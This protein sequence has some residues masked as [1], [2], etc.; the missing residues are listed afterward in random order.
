MS[1]T[2]P[3]NPPL[4]LVYY[5]KRNISCLRGGREFEKGLSPLS[6]GYSPEKNG[7]KLL[8]IERD[9]Q[10]ITVKR[11]PLLKVKRVV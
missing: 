3:L 11:N 4:K 7:V 2:H 8:M 1:Y 9:C 5:Y 10:A 6:A